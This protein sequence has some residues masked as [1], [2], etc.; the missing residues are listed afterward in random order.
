MKESPGIA[1]AVVGVGA[2]LPDAGDAPA[3]WRNVKEGRYSITEVPK[4]RWDPDLHFDPDPAAPDR[5]YS[6]IGGW[7]R[8][9]DWEWNPIAWR[10]PIPPIVGAS[11]EDS[12]KWAVACTR[13]ALTDYGYPER[14]LN[15]ERTAVVLGNAL[16]GDRQFLTGLRILYPQLAEEFARTPAVMALPADV[17]SAVLDG[18]RAGMGNLVPAVTGDTV[19]GEL[20]NI[21]AGRVANLF[22]LHGPNCTIDAACASALAAMYTS[23]K[24]LVDG[25]FDAAVTGGID[26]NMGP[27][28]FVKFSKLG[29]LS[30]TGTRPYDEG[31][32]GFV[33]GEGAAMFLLKRLADAERDG[34]RI[35]AVIRGLAGS[36]DGKGRGLTAPNPIGQR[37]AVQRAWER[38]GVSP[39]TATMIEGHGTSTALG[40]LVEAECLNEVFGPLGLPAGSIAL[41]SV[42]SNIGHLKAAAGAAG[43]LKTVLALHEKVLPPSI[44]FDRPNPSVDWA[45]AP[46]SVNTELR[47]WEIPAGGVRR[48]GVSAFG[49]G[50]TNFHAV[51]EEYDPGASDANGRTTFAVPEGRPEAPMTLPGGAVAPKAPLR[52]TLVLGAGSTVELIAE[53]R[54]IQAAA[55]SGTVPPAR[56][57]AESDLRAPERVA[58]DFG[59]AA[60]LA[61]K[62]ALALH[63]LAAND[64]DEW[65]A[66]HARGIFR[67]SGPPPKVAFLYSGQ[68]SQYVN[69]LATL[70][71]SE[72]AVADVFDRADRLL[73]AELGRSLSECVFVATEDPAA[74]EAAEA[75]LARTEMTQPAVLAA[76]LALSGLLAEY[77]I[78]PDMVMGHSLGEYAALVAAGCLSF[79]HALRAV[80]ARGRAVSSLDL[81][82]PGRMAAVFAPLPE[83]E[84]IL[85]AIDGN[86]AVANYNSNGQAVITGASGPVAR[87]VD[88]FEAAGHRVV[89]LSISHAFHNPIVA[90]AS[91]PLRRA[92]AELDLQPAKLPVVANVTGEFYPTGPDAVPRMLD[93]LT[94]QIVSPV[95][96]V[97]G[98]ETLYEAGARVFVELGPKSAAHG[99]ADDVLGRRADVVPLFTNH[100]KTGDVVSF[101]HALC[102]LYAAGLGVGIAAPERP[103]ELP[104]ER[105]RAPIPMPARALAGLA[106]ADALARRVPVPVLRPPLEICTPT[107]VTLRS[108]SR[109]V[110]MPD[111]GGVSTELVRLLRDRGV[112]PLVVDHDSEP[113]A[114][115]E[116]LEAWAGEGAIHGV[117]WLP[118]LDAEPS[119]VAMTPGE[120]RQHI[121]RRVKLL[122]TAMR[123]LY[124]SVAGPESFLVVATR[125]GGMHGYDEAG[126][127]APMGGAV[128]GFAKAYKRERMVPLVK[129]VD[130]EAAADP[131]RVAALIVDETLRDPNAVEIG[132]RDGLRWSVALRERPADDGNPG[133]P[134]TPQT[135]FVVTGAAGGIVSA[136]V[137]DLAAASGGT[138]HLLDL[139]PEPDP[140]DPDIARF[141]ADRDGLKRELFERIRARGERATPVMAE[142]ELRAVERRQAALSAIQAVRASGGTVT[143]HE[144]DL[145]DAGQVAAT[146]DDI[147][148]LHGRIDVLVHAAGIEISHA[149]PDKEPR[150]FDLVFDVKADGW[151]NLL[152]AI[153]DMPLGATVAFTSVAGRF[154]NAGQTDYAA[155]NDLLCKHTSSLR[156]SRPGTR[157]IAVDWTAWAG[158]GMATRGSIPQAMAAAGI[159]MMPPENGIPVVRR[160]LVSGGTRGEVVIAGSLGTLTEDWDETGGL[161]LEL[162][163]AV[164]APAGAVGPMVGRVAAMTVHDGLTVET[165]LDPR[166]QPFLFDHRMDG[167]DL[168][169][170]VMGAEAFAEVAALALPGWRVAAIEDMRY[171]AAFKFY[172]DEP[173][174]LVLRAVFRPE[175]DEIVADCRLIGRRTLP[176]RP[177]P[178]VTTHFTGSVRLTRAPLEPIRVAPVP[179]PTDGFVDAADIY[180][181]YFH[182][183]SYQVL[184][185]AWPQAAGGVALGLFPESPPPDRAPAEAPLVASPRLIELCYQTIGTWELGVLGRFGLPRSFER[186]TLLG[187]QASGRAPLVAVVRPRGNGEAFDAEV[188][189]AEGLVV[190]QLR[191]YRSTELPGAIGPDQLRTFRVAAG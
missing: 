178:V 185:R 179:L 108:P 115:Q 8:E 113:A 106:P 67:G 150:E 187:G 3:F 182:G 152:H 32:D 39:A 125:L 120:W 58:L 140:D 158:I 9:S 69:M 6:K 167:T 143:Y 172:R 13:E 114:L 81:E 118:A 139:A 45:H 50:G 79:E 148:R 169:P 15:T 42:K 149:L 130:V 30:G 77:G 112:T 122:F 47:K 48:A 75:D 105:E 71:A 100:P 74:L 155:A 128:T 18:L 14:P 87:A 190:L 92:L 126:A 95:Q 141:V 21:L 36:S 64:P 127:V 164:L 86:V 145:T 37:L 38:A 173:R 60:E 7:V 107:G 25:D 168:L 161:D 133:L 72:P 189:D 88:A 12:Q 61:D 55:R 20:S 29:A 59:D 136:I 102:G 89:P 80:S 186:V 84:E 181:V 52:P 22:D 10:L 160:E 165:V 104:T 11:M 156:S 16:A 73:A 82:D 51:L 119:V 31:A 137:A 83:I 103:T 177:E 93:T 65:R 131:A 142:R 184:E 121:R 166:V 153:G 129:A 68:G 63:A 43:L 116:R 91:E 123:A 28:P 34:D 174:T 134:L 2:I 170:G 96:F 78:A 146:I 147:R 24:G 151:F 101:N 5:T 56:P 94:A 159:D 27:T 41:G 49:F 33:M 35:Y 109:V 66:L 124:E 99:F 23:V 26:G 163:G 46:F 183:P 17:R 110:L 90:P 176:V 76:D 85:R 132:Y 157:G 54:S 171:E 44:N 98:L 40:D 144:L 117:Y 180:R 53:L 57:P 97:K 138:F 175:G 111:R 70:R 188:V 19:L 191:G 62:A 135:V 154:G 4:E 1:V 162:A